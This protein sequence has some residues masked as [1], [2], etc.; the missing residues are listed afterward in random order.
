MAN[1]KHKMRPSRKA[2]DHAFLRKCHEEN[3]L[4]H[5]SDSKVIVDF[6]KYRG[7]PLA[8]VPEHW[9]RWCAENLDWCPAYITDELEQR[10][11]GKVKPKPPAPKQRKPRKERKPRQV[12]GWIKGEH[13]DRLEQEFLEAGGDPTSCPFDCPERGYL[14]EQ[15]R[16]VWDG[17][18]PTVVSHTQWLRSQ[19]DYLG[20]LFPFTGE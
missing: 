15:P 1:K 19:G 8:V 12:G 18:H 17:D 10:T 2:K 11:L 3:G 16:I 9:L 20:E 5:H 13:S 7:E 6:G 4:V 14:V